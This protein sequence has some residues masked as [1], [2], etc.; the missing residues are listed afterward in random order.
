MIV[1]ERDSKRKKVRWSG[2]VLKTSLRMH[3]GLND[4]GGPVVFVALTGPEPV[5]PDQKNDAEP[6]EGEV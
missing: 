5:P 1:S 3:V 2:V 6:P 4:G